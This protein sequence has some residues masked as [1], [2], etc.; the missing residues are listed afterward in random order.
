VD[1]YAGVD[2][3]ELVGGGI[4][5]MKDDAPDHWGAITAIQTARTIRTN[6]PPTKA[7]F[8]RRSRSFHQPRTVPLISR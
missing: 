2:V 3:T 8:A 4:G 6:G 1:I 5:V 7:A